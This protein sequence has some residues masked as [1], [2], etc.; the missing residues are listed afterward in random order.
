MDTGLDA[1][2]FNPGHTNDLK[3]IV[4]EETIKPYISLIPS[5]DHENETVE[6]S[7]VP[8]DVLKSWLRDTRFSQP[9]RTRIFK[10]VSEQ[11][12]SDVAPIPPFKFAQSQAEAQGN[13]DMV[14]RKKD[15][16]LKIKGMA[17]PQA[18]IAK[19]LLSDLPEDITNAELMELTQSAISLVF[20][21]ASNY[22]KRE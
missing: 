4:G 22:S 10:N 11:I 16:I 12:N 6:E 17:A 7:H 15:A 3:D 5:R 14:Q 18:R 20:E 19:D 13:M 8:S 2:H 1:F 21:S 9:D